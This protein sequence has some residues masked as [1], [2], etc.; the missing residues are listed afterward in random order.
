[1]EYLWTKQEYSTHMFYH[2]YVLP[3]L[4]GLGLGFAIEG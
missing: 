1:M 2:P 4:S 3:A